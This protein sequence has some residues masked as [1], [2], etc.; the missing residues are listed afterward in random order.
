M[1]HRQFRRRTKGD[2]HKLNQLK[3]T[4]AQQ[5]PFNCLKYLGELKGRT[6]GDIHKLNQLKITPAQQ[7][8][9]NCLKYLRFVGN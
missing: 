5:L 2:I 6:K 8:P 4:P 1:G 3:I 7:L 9:F